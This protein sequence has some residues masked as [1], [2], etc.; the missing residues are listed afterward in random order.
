LSAERVHKLA[1]DHL[2]HAYEAL[3]LTTHGAVCDALAFSPD[4]AD[5]L[6][7]STT[8]NCIGAARRI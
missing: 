5:L 8:G 7:A 6:V 3:R 1:G 2:E 4:D